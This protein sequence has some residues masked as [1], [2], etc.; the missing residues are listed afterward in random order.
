MN[1]AEL[2]CLTLCFA[3][4]GQ[5][6]LTCHLMSCAR[7]PPPLPPKGFRRVYAMTLGLQFG[8][9]SSK[10]GPDCHSAVVPLVVMGLEETTPAAN[11]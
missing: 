7:T 2:F 8:Y 3:L 1:Q 5:A 10:F 6:W 9:V 11:C 4:V